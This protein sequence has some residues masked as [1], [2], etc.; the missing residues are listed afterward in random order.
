[1]RA[2]IRS[3]SSASVWACNAPTIE[4]ARNVAGLKD[5][6]SAEFDEQTPHPVIHLMSD[7]QSVSDKGGTMRLGSYTCRAWRGNAGAKNV[8]SGEV[9]ER[10]R[11]RYEFNN[12]YRDRLTAK[13]SC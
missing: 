9:R 2:S 12:A 3:R 5:A 4:F 11:H 13:G 1:M 6:N 8:R 10:H 7:Q